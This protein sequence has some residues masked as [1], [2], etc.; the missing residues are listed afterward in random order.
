MAQAVVAEQY[1]LLWRKGGDS[2]PPLLSLTGSRLQQ[3]P[4]KMYES[5]LLTRSS[6]KEETN[7]PNGDMTCLAVR[8][9]Q[10]MINGLQTLS[11]SC[12]PF[13]SS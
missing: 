8:K 7:Y 1:K 3:S 2:S 13:S 5:P 6:Q 4:T 12:P 10:Q 11:K 9:L